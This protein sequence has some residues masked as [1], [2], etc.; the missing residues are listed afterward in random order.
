VKIKT[1]EEKKKKH[2]IYHPYMHACMLLY[3]NKRMKHNKER[4]MV[5]E[6]RR[7]RKGEGNG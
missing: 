4:Y 2:H 3:L 1:R 5:G 7:R 6:R